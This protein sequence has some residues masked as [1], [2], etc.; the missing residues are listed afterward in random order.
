MSRVNN[1]QLWIEK[2]FKFKLLTFPYQSRPPLFPVRFLFSTLIYLTLLRSQKRDKKGKIVY[3]TFLILRT[4]NETSLCYGGFSH[5]R[6][7]SFKQ[8]KNAVLVDSF[9][10]PVRESSAYETKHNNTNPQN[11]K[12]ATQYDTTHCQNLCSKNVQTFTNTENPR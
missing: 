9:C 5:S 1:F 6:K 10:F 4:S 2:D 12:W 11:N 3:T 7:D 8:I